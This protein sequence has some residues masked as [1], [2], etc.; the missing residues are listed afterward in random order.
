MRKRIFT[1][2]AGLA[3]YHVTGAEGLCEEYDRW[4]VRRDVRRAVAQQFEYERRVAEYRAAEY[5][6]AVNR[7][8]QAAWQADYQRQLYYWRNP[9][10]YQPAAPA[11]I[12]NP[13]CK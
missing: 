10:P 6:A 11:V 1:L 13:F 8:R 4:Q 3:I 12:D 9:R 2:L 7:A 5:Q